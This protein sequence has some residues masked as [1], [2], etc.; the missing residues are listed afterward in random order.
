M[1]RTPFASSLTLGLALAL[2]IALVAPATADA[3]R[4]VGG[5]EE[6]DD[7]DEKETGGDAEAERKKQEKAAAEAKKKEA[8]KKERERKKREAQEAARK[9]AEEKKRKADEAAKKKAAAEKAAAEKKA[10]ADRAAML[11]RAAKERRMRRQSDNFEAKFAVLPGKAASGTVVEVR[12]VLSENLKVPDPRYGDVKPVSKA[13]LVAHVNEPP[14]ETKRR[15]KARE[16]NFVVHPLEQPGEYGFHFTP[17]NAA[18]VEIAITGRTRDGQSLS[19]SFPI[20]VDTW[21]PPDFPAE[22]EAFR[23]NNRGGSESRSILD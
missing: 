1:K 22:E 2:G 13:T 17:A 6:P 18:T 21:P 11:K 20:H 14:P 8:A 15:A 16:R 5:S 19:L 7:D 9:A 12:M 3:R 4:P 23:K 10:K